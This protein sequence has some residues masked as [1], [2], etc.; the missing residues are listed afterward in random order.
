[1]K[2]KLFLIFALI[3]ALNLPVFASKIPTDLYKYIQQNLKGAKQRFDSVIVLPDGVMYVPLYPAV[4]ADVDKIEITYTY[5]A[6]S[7]TL[8]K[9]PEVVIF[10]NNYVLLKVFKNKAG[11]YTITSNEE[12]PVKVKLGV[13]P[14]D[15]L[16]PPG[17]VVPENLRLILGDLAIPKPEDVTLK[18]PQSERVTK[19]SPIPELKNK[20]LYAIS[21]SSNFLLAMDSS[22]STGL[23]ELKLS[24]APQKIL[25]APSLG[26]AAVIYYNQKYFDILDLKNERIIAQIQTDAPLEDLSVDTQNNLAYASA[27]SINTIYTVDLNSL[28][29][30]KKI[31]VS[32]NPERL[33]SAFD[34]K[35]LVYSDKYSGD[36]FLLNLSGEYVS[37]FVLNAPNTFCAFLKDEDLYTLSRGHS[38]LNKIDPFAKLLKGE[39]PLSEKPVDMLYYNDKIFILS[40][41]EASVN[42]FDMLNGT[43]IKTVKIDNKGFYTK[44]TRV[45]NKQYAVITGFD[46]AKLAVM[47]LDKMAVVQKR[48]TKT[49]IS[50]LVILDTSSG[51]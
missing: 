6:S 15:M 51:L 38:N 37:S 16:V 4:K 20:K 28:K 36:F 13:M 49:D 3:F 29:L 11:K 33:F 46:G 27:P 48:P 50:G 25:G 2:K 26:Y 40:A 7:N 19:Y 17:L 14:Q 35:S 42:V 22:S 1:M 39:I 34:G 41:K 5:P 45:P 32:T 18:V 10:N 30:T 31:K 9:R 23:Y 47:D 24:A 21:P 44:I 12:L 8:N 43:L